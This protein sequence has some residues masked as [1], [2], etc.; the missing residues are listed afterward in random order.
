MS[1]GMGG[2]GDNQKPGI[3]ATVVALNPDGVII[4]LP[5]GAHG[6]IP[7]EYLERHDVTVSDF[8]VEE[9]FIVYQAITKHKGGRRETQMLNGL[10]VFCLSYKSNNGNI[11][12]SSKLD[13]I[14]EGIDIPFEQFNEEEKCDY[15]F[16]LLEGLIWED[17][18]AMF[19]LDDY[20]QNRR[21]KLDGRAERLLIAK[22]VLNEDG[23]LPDRTNDVMYEMRTGHRPFWLKN[24]DEG[25]IIDISEYLT[26]GPGES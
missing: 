6:I 17:M 16:N 22:Y 10:P 4:S 23:T 3:T 14:K 12:T 15:L 24:K 8:R 19:Q 25:K 20:C 9:S 18:D 2:M 5:E 1:Y 21:D 7:L 11:Y 26:K 13:R